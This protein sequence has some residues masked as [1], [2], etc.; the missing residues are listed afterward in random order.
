MSSDYELVTELPGTL[1]T[2]E[3]LHRIHQRYKLAAEWSRGKR[4]LEVGCGAGLGLGYLNQ[5]AAS[6]VGGDRSEHLLRLGRSHYGVRVPLVQLDAQF[7]PFRDGSFDTAVALETIYYFRDPR[8]FLQE[9]RRLLAPGGHLVIS[10]VNNQWSGFSASHLSQTYLSASQLVDSLMESGYAVERVMGGFP[11]QGSVS[12]STMATL[13]A[14]A[15]RLH[16]IPKTL[17]GR[18]VL[19]RLFY[20]PLAPLPPE[21]G[22]RED[23]SDPPEVIDPDASSRYS[24]Y[25]VV[26]RAP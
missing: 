21:V 14:T 15:A 20:G 22:L 3:Q 8:M 24:I 12:A 11:N 1:A 10:S 16:L 23:G 9:A 5:A 18:R 19:K 7:L 17:Q 2:N 4:T 13:R 25:Y 26:A 6:V